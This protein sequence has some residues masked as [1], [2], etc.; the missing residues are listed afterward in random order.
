MTARA[1]IIAIL[2]LAACVRPAEDR[3][4]ADLDVGVAEAGGAVFTVADG[5][6]S[7]RDASPGA[8]TL[9]AQAPV[10]DLR[11]ELSAGATQAWTL[12]CDNCMPG[13]AL[14]A[15]SE[16]GNPVPI[17]PLPSPRPTLRS[18]ELTLPAGET[19]ELTIATADA[20]DLTPWRF[21]FLADIQEGVDDVDDIYQRINED[22]TI[23]FVVFG[24]DLT[25]RGTREEIE[26]NLS[27]LS[28]LNVPM[29]MTIGNHEL[30]DD[31]ALWE[32]L[33]G[34]RNFHFAYRGAHFS[35]VD[36]AS[37]TIDPRVYDR[38]DAWLEAA[39]N[40]VHVY[41]SHY[42]PF[43]P[44]GIREGGFRSRKE[45]AKL[46]SRL[47]EGRVDGAFVGHIHSYYAHEIADVP[48]WIAGGGGA[49]PQ[50]HLDGVG[51]HYLTIDVEPGE[52]IAQVA[53]VRIE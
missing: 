25:D 32:E 52:R 16:S 28:A 27:E 46:M 11:A 12:T 41:V 2:A 38:L 8:L 33:I 47:R 14:V 37:A 36:S 7:V 26:R 3:A 23:R 45:A 9:W 17:T 5:L 34:V 42:P 50:E 21:A 10:L 15:T 6:A 40:D 43:D 19:T 4:A 18:W 1:S 51:R 30:F 22:P 13:A 31:D 24:G 44:I 49:F 20:A 29:Y 48:V 39:R 53:L 35:F